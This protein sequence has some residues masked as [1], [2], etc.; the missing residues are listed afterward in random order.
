MW[1][2]KMKRKNYGSVGQQRL[3]HELARFL[4]VNVKRHSRGTP[5]FHLDIFPNFLPCNPWKMRRWELVK[6]LFTLDPC[7]FVLRFW[8]CGSSD[9]VP[10][11]QN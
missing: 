1:P 8:G 5:I 2:K 4:F 9:E 10:A 7:F 6:S 11:L 3:K